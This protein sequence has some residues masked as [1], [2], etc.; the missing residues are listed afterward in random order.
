MSIKSR[1]RTRKHNKKLYKEGSIADLTI[2][3]IKNCKNI[4]EEG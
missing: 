3:V 1:I 2:R 4:T